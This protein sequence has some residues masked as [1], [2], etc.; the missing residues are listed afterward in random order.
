MVVLIDVTGSMSD[1]H[2][3][4]G[5]DVRSIVENVAVQASGGNLLTANIF[6]GVMS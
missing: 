3:V 1:A 2:P 5:T 4:I 6:K